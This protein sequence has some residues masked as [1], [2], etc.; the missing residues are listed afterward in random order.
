MLKVPSHEAAREDILKLDKKQ[1]D[2]LKENLQ[3]IQ[4]VAC[5]SNGGSAHGGSSYIDV[6]IHYI[7]DQG[8]LVKKILDVVPVEN[9]KTAA[10]YRA[11]VESVG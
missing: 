9:G 8:D 5:T 11:M 4:F 1:Q 10:E 2:L 7:N 3:N 6:N